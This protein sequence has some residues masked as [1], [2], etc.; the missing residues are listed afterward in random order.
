[1]LC[2]IR[3]RRILPPDRFSL[4]GQKPRLSREEK[5]LPKKY[6]ILRDHCYNYPGHSLHFDP[7][8]DI[9]NGRSPIG[10]DDDERYVHSS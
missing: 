2:N 4:L 7:Y 3:I 8:F 10:R 6:H 9:G 1:M 5:M